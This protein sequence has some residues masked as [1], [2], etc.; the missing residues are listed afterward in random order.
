VRRVA[1]LALLGLVAGCAAKAPLI[2]SEAAPLP[3][4]GYAA[5][6]HYGTNP[7]IDSAEEATVRV[8]LSAD[9][10]SWALVHHYLDRGRMPPPEAV[11]VEDCVAAMA[12]AP[13]SRGTS[14]PIA[15]SIA[16]LPSPFRAGWHT[17]VV[18]VIAPGERLAMRASELL[19]VSRTPDGPLERAFVDLGA[20]IRTGDATDLAHALSEAEHVVLVGDGAGLGGP[21]AQAPLLELIARAH[22]R[23]T[24]VSVA[25]LAAPG[26]DDA[27]LD[28]IAEAGGGLHDL[29]V[30][31]EEVHLARRFAR[32]GGLDDLIAE[33]RLDPRAVTRWRLIGHES[34]T[35]RAAGLSPSG[36]R[37]PAAEAIDLILELD[38]APSSPVTALGR[39]HLRARDVALDAPLPSRVADDARA[40]AVIVIAAL[41][42]KLRGSFWVK[43]TAWDTIGAEVDRLGSPALRS[44]LR[45]VVDRARALLASDARPERP[46]TI[47][48][49]LP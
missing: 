9:R 38:L 27:L 11:R 10:A 36:G 37:L 5:F 4:G 8:G 42:E 49:R 30:P 45:G 35:V 6:A 1:P 18:T 32:A 12:P 43:D 3:G 48:R 17:L 34:R 14:A 28:R 47:V 23:G 40:H 20:R 7:V 29:V 13:P 16:L 44:E 2:Q 31:G 46:S 15:I 24:I 39:V 22:A 41:A 33:V 19:V 21:D 25:G 26:L